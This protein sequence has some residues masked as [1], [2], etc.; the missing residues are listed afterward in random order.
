M[1]NKFSIFILTLVLAGL[2]LSCKKEEKVEPV[3]LT[4][5]PSESFLSAASNQVLNFNIKGNGDVSLSKFKITYKEGNGPLVTLLD[6]ALTTKQLSTLFSFQ[7]PNY[8]LQ[9][10]Y[11]SFYFE[12]YD[13]E[14]NEKVQAKGVN[15]LVANRP[16]SEMVNHE[17]Y[18]KAS[19]K[20]NA[21]DLRDGQAIYLSSPPT[22][23][24]NISDTVTLDSLSKTWISPS[25]GLF[26]KKNNFD[27]DNATLLS[28]KN[29]FE[30]GAKSNKVLNLAPGDIILFRQM[31]GVE[32]FYAVI[33][34]TAINNP[35][36]L[37]NDRYTFA[38][39]K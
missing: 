38:V 23:I 12:L 16:L 27:Y 19:G 34:M 6:S 39:K 14:G 25:G 18:S 22:P 37:E 7:I 36:G 31:Y 24:M 1:M 5:L 9:N 28:V 2:M 4:V 30:G 29:D 20:P 35:V 11:L 21:F 3:R 32:A 10:M 17:M 26:V 13:S 33:K 8:G 15:V